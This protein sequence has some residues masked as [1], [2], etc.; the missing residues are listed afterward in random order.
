MMEIFLYILLL[1]L[2][3]VYVVPTISTVALKVP[4]VSK[5]NLATVIVRPTGLTAIS[6]AFNVLFWGALLAAT[7]YVFSL[8]KPAANALKEA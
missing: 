1:G 5:L 3:V 8:V 4:G 6:V 2:A 7:L